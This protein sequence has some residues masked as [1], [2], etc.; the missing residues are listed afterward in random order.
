MAC[1]FPGAPDLASFWANVLDGVDAVTEVPADRWDPA[2]YY[3]VRQAHVEVGRVPAGGPVRPAGLRHPA[4]V[5]AAHRT[6]AAAGAGGRAAGAGRRRLHHRFDRDRAVRDLRRRGRQRPG[7]RH[8]AAVDAA[9]ATSTAVPPEL[10]AQLP[11]LTEDSFPGDA[12]Q[13]HRRPHRQPA[14]P[15]RRELHGGRR[16]RVVAGRAGR[17]VQGARRRHQRPGAVRRRRPAQRHPRLPAVHLGR[18][19]VPDR[20]LAPVR[21]H[22]RRHRARRGRRRA[23]C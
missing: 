16:V 20:P 2:I 10:A 7:Q 17:G 9:L 22:R 19:A 23:S 4:V 3:D 18:R 15:R 21:P 5:A 14:R 8:R 6:R 11:E 13:R 1:V 12:G